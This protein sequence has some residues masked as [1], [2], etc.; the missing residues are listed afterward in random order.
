MVAASASEQHPLCVCWGGVQ[1]WLKLNYV[2]STQSTAY[3]VAKDIS[4]IISI[5]NFLGHSLS[6]ETEEITILVPVSRPASFHPN[7]DLEVYTDTD[8]DVVVCY[9]D[10]RHTPIQS[11]PLRKLVLSFKRFIILNNVYYYS[12]TGT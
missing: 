6:D 7:S 12:R 2:Q 4:T 5:N 8:T 11:Q 3:T 10:D 9:R 1:V